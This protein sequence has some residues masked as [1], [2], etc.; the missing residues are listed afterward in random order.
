MV[1]L[2]LDRLLKIIHFDSLYREAIIT[3]CVLKV[4][5]LKMLSSQHLLIN[6]LCPAG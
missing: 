5:F 1:S 6:L 2:F 3:R 4:N